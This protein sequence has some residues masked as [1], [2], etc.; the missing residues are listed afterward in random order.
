M[1]YKKFSDFEQFRPPDI[2]DYLVGYRELASEYK[3]TIQDIAEVIKNANAPFVPNTIYVNMSGNDSFD[4]S[5]EVFAVRT[6]KRAFAI[7][8]GKARD[9]S[10]VDEL[11]EEAAD[12]WGIRSNSVNVFV[13]SGDYVED[14][15]IYIPPCCTM[16]GDNLRSTSIRPKNRCYDIFWVNHRNYLYGVTYRDHLAPAFAVAYPEMAWLSNEPVIGYPDTRVREATARAFDFYTESPITFPA[17]RNRRLSIVNYANDDGDPIFDPFRICFLDRYFIG[18]N[19]NFYTSEEILQGKQF[20]ETK[21]FNLSTSVQKPYQLT[22]PY[23]Q[24]SSSITHPSSAGRADAGGGILVDGYKVRGPLRSFVTDSF[25]Q[26]NEGGR[27]IHIKNNGYAQLVSTF[28]ICCIDSVLCEDGGSCSISTSNS[29]FGL[30]GLVA[31]G[32]S[33]KATL[34]GTL[35]EAVSSLTNV[36]VITNLGNSTLTATQE[37]PDDVQP[38]PG[39]VFE[40]IDRNYLRVDLPGFNYLSATNSGSFF[41]VLCA[42]PVKPAEAPYQGWESTIVLDRNYAFTEDNSIFG[43][44]IRYIDPDIGSLSVGSDVNFYIRSTITASAHTFEYIGTGTE[45]LKSI[46]QKGGVTKVEN[47]VVFDDVGRVFFTSTNQFGDFRIG[48]GLTIIQATG[49]IEGE[50]FDRSILQ[51]VT[52]LIIALS[53]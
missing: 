26:F 25:T 30:S 39:Q 11:V 44:G 19:E 28:T 8:L 3:A 16:I 47:E 2:S 33:P 1:A 14:N 32:K 51:K 6:I 48:R 40:I 36:F 15:P 38:Y 13:R 5:S 18:I 23:T 49:S 29:S 52:P 41:S 4:G 42:T 45:L 17:T 37:F 27:G 10:P 34:R 21:W 43:D 22:S 53:D 24:G 46:P 20:W 7:A 50:T 31:L 12:A 9:I 35:K